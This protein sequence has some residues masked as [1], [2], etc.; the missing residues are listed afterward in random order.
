MSSPL[1][2]PRLVI[3][4]RDGVLNHE[5]PGGY[6][7]A[8]AD[9]RWQSGALQALKHL[10]RGRQLMVATNQSCVGR[11]LTTAEDIDAVHAHF[12][13]TVHAADAHVDGIFVCPHLPDAGCACRKPAPGLLLQ[14]LQSAGVKPDEAL[15]VGDAVTDFQAA[16]AAGVRFALVRT[17]KG[18]ASEASG[19][20]S[21]AP[22]FDDLMAVALGVR[23]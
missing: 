1:G 14:A 9:W 16:Q 4:D 8:V 12:L 13:T 2:N 6:V 23:G 7:M 15:F 19:L 5:G 17:G 22:V 21:G 18:A 10:G 20:I 3:L 11:G